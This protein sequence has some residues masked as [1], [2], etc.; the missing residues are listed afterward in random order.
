MNKRVERTIQKIYLEI[1]KKIYNTS[2]I[3]ALSRG[4]REQIISS[5]AKMN[6]SESYDQFCKRYA[7][8]LASQ[9]ILTRRGT[10]RKFYEEAKKR[11]MVG[12]PKT[13]TEFETSILKN[14]ITHN[15]NMI[16]SIPN[17]T[18]K[19]LEHK[20]T[21]TLI[22]E[23]AK[24]QLP[25]GSFQKQ[26]MSHGHKNAK[27]IARTETAKLQTAITENR[28]LDLG[29]VAYIWLASNDRRTRPSHRAMNGVVVFWRPDTQKPLLD[30]MRGNAGEFP[31]CRCDPQAIFDEDDLDKNQYKVYDYKTDKV[32]T[33]SKNEL[34]KAMLNKGL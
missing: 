16:K 18:L 34:T 8:I 20:Y 6:T 12:L 26:L 4:S 15:F 17:E 28:A 2:N 14:A 25:R 22:E 33:M 10:W 5:V 31:N 9:G 27:L 13:W 30:N 24:G 7:K 3:I 11:R 32:I 19:M 21:S 23:V 29:S 1:L